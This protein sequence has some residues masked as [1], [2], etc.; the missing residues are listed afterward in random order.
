MLREEGRLGISFLHTDTAGNTKKVER[1]MP[2]YENKMW[3]TL[4][5]SIENQLIYGKKSKFPGKDGYWAA[6]GAGLHQQLKDSW[7]DYFTGPITAKKLQD[8]LMTIFFAR[9]DEQNRRVV[10]YTGSLGRLLFHNAMINEARQFLTVDTLYQEKIASTTDVPHIAYGAEITRYRGPL[11]VVIDVVVNPAY[12]SATNCKI[13]HPDYPDMP[14]DSARMTFLDFGT[15]DGQN[16]IMV[17]KEK[18]TFR[19]GYTVGNQ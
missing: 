10:L 3:E 1:F 16:N 2:Y 14:I 19:H 6:T 12:D 11:G 13:Y 5:R 15:S 8:F 9:E 4:Y 17:L 7:T 18:D